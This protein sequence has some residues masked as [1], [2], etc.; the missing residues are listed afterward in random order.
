[1]TREEKAA[2]M[3]KYRERIKQ[4]KRI[5]IRFAK[6]RGANVTYKR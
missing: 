5:P 2:R 6:R 4:L 3:R 1:M